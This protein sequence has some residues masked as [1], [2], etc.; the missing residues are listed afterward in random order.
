MRA[1]QPKGGWENDESAEE[2]AKREGWEE[3]G[4]RGNI[5]KSLGSF[6]HD[7]MDETGKPVSEFLFYEMEVLKLE[8][9]W[10]EGL[11]RQRAW[12]RWGPF[13]HYTGENCVLIGLEN[14]TVYIR[15]SIGTRSTSLYA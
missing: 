11:E 2:S 5:T 3:A 15:R 1:K 7:K 14:E 4:I 12:V 9:E 10:P 8:T 6:L 13:S